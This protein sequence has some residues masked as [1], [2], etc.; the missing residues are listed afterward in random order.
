[1]VPPFY[2]RRLVP[3]VLDELAVT[4]PQRVYAAIPRTADVKD[5]YQ[6]ITVADLARCVNFTSKWIEEKFGTSSNFET[7]T[8]IGLSDLRSIVTLLA[9][10]KTGYKLLI[11][12]PRNPASVNYH[13]MTQTGSGKV[14]YAAELEPLIQPLKTLLPTAISD[15]V[16]SLQVMLESKPEPY[17]YRKTFEEARY[18][19]IAVLH[20]SG[21]TGLPKPITITNGSIAAHDGDLILPAP[22]GRKKQDTS[23]FTLSRENRRLYLILPFFHLGGFIFFTDYAILGNLTLVLGPAHVAPDALLLREVAEQQPLRAIMVVP[24]IIEQLLHDPKGEDLLK[25]LDFVT[26]AGAPLSASVGDRVARIVRLCNFIGSTET[27][28]LP[29]LQKAPDDWQ[30]HEFNPYLKHE[31]QLYDESTETFELVIH[32][33]DT[34]QD[35]APVYHNLPGVNPFYT[36]DLFTKHPTKPNL[37]KYYGRRDDILVLANGEKMNPIPLEQHVQGDSRLKGVL[38]I[39]NGRIQTN[40]LLEPNERLDE[41]GKL[42]LLQS[43]WPRIEQA[44]ANVPGQGR[45]RRGMVIC[46]SP[47]KPFA[48]TG[49]GTIIRKLTEKAYEDEID[50]LYSAASLQD[51]FIDVNLKSSPATG[52]EPAAINR[53]LRQIITASFP[54]ASTIGETEDFFAHGLDSIQTLEITA[55]LKRNL[56]ALTP[57]SVTWIKPRIIFQHST[58]DSLTKVLVNFLTGAVVPLEDSQKVR[59]NAVEDAV[60]RY[61]KDLPVSPP[62]VAGVGVD[63]ANIIVAVIGSTGYVGTHLL[64]NLLK[65]SAISHIYCLDRGSD[66]PARLAT[67]LKEIDKDLDTSKLTFFKIKIGAPSLGF[68]QDQHYQKI[69]SE[70]DVV[71]YNSW[72]LDFGLALHSFDPFLRTTSDLIKLSVASQRNIRIVFV[73]SMSSVEGYAFSGSTVPEALVTDPLAALNT[74]YGQS[75]LVAERILVTANQRAGVPVSIVRL[76]QVGGSSRGNC[77]WADQP[78]ISALIRT[79]K[80]LGSFPNPVVPID[81]VPV[82]SV[83]TVLESVIVKSASFPQPC[84]VFNVVSEPQS[85]KVLVEAVRESE[86]AAVSEIVSLQDWVHKLLRVS[87]PSSADIQKLPALRMLDFY[88]GLGSGCESVNYATEHTKVISGLDLAPVDRALLVSW[89][90]T[91]NL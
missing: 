33:D 77:V 84:E 52:Y 48:R 1:M 31:M 68:E 37:Y 27:F 19:P 7:I 44:N 13:L 89:L 70:V 75:K 3:Q 20:S 66:A 74:G 46:A 25:S 83:A 76:G 60:A 91:W 87:N 45:V 62:H 80:A 61:V 59:A 35:Q 29:E 79:S 64:A 30:Y 51:R 67:S 69:V 71:L 22:A 15:A 28:P 49:K 47:D 65:N 24:A 5:G 72:R 17:H 41:V 73:S 56:Q 23:L 55:N 85:W 81:W 90:K 8:Y 39:G 16:P 38:L 10:I 50:Y 32:A 86:P 11:P 88:Q 2:G 18:N 63:A 82:D 54:A 12:S 26:C 6:D 36:R 58:L 4:D 21:S 57:N 40:L 42:H 14:L 43:L 9:A 53:F 78:W 34:T